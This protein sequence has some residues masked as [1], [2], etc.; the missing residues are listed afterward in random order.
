[1][2]I[3]IIE[4]GRVL[5][6]GTIS[7]IT[8]FLVAKMVGK[9]QISQLSIF[10]YVIGISIGNFAAEMTINLETHFLS[11]IVAVVLYGLVALI[12]S[13][14]TMKSITLRRYFTGVP[15]ILMQG[16]RLIEKN[17]KKVKLDINDFLEECRI[18]GYFDLSEIE[19]AVMETN[20]HISFLPKSHYKPVTCKDMK[21]ETKFQGLQSNVIIDTKIMKNNLHEM[22]KDEEWLLHQLKIKGYN[23]T[24][25]I[26]LATLDSN[27]K[28]IIYNKN[29]EEGYE[30]LA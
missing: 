23:D 6:R 17:L 8:L 27:D 4:L 5:G 3:N 30:I 15:T 14:I 24:S 12:V 2:N 28:L 25:Q 26:L 22:K 16:G 19:F 13:I 21:I 20:G 18:A 11:G 10:D 7:L 9:K 29:E 1:M